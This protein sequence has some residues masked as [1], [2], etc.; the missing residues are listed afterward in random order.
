MSSVG[1]TASL[2]EH[3]KMQLAAH[4]A[5]FTSQQL[6]DD[7]GSAIA[8]CV[9]PALLAMPA[10]ERASLG[11]DSR[12]L[13]CPSRHPLTSDFSYSWGTFDLEYKEKVRPEFVGQ[14]RVSPVTGLMERH[15]P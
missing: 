11:H 13:H 2:C 12:A 5:P 8:K 7:K 9:H 4:W 10:C 6:C 3:T 15:F 1:A 14:L